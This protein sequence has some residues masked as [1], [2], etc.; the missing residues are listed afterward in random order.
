MLQEVQTALVADGKSPKV[1]TPAVLRH[2]LREAGNMLQPAEVDDVLM[3]VFADR[4]FLE[5]DQLY[6][7]RLRNDTVQQL[8]CKTSLAPQQSLAKEFYSWRA[9]RSENRF[10]LLWDSN[11]KQVVDSPAWRRIAE[12]VAEPLSACL[13]ACI[14]HKDT[15]VVDM[16]GWAQKV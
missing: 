5:L 13:L 7:V 6:L 15:A 9:A 3:Y 14:S 12:Y 4:K 11:G 10:K 8:R 1:L 2:K 16:L